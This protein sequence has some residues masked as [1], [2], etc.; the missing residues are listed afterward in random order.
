MAFKFTLLG[1]VGSNEIKSVI[2]VAPFNLLITFVV[3]LSGFPSVSASSFK[4]SSVPGAPLISWFILASISTVL[5]ASFPDVSYLPAA[6]LYII[7]CP[8]IGSCG[9]STI[10]VDATRCVTE[11]VST[12]DLAFLRNIMYLINI[13]LNTKL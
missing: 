8:S 2:A 6:A 5:T 1:A 11:R 3:K 4:V 12:L 10:S 7:N 9:K 13:F